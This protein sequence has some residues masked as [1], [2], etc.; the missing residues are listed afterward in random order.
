MAFSWGFP[1]CSCC[2]AIGIFFQIFGSRWR[3]D[4]GSKAGRQGT[5]GEIRGG[6]D[7]MKGG[8]GVGGASV[9]GAGVGGASSG[10]RGD[11]CIG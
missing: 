8:A 6:G 11:A 2:I 4:N 10:A 1:C 7:R 3:L 5:G 9:G